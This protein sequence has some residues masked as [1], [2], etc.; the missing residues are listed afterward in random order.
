MSTLGWIAAYVAC[1]NIIGFILMGMDK[2]KAR[3]HAWRIAE[4][5]FFVVA[6]LGG[7]LGSILG[8]YTFRHKT[9]HWYFVVFMPIILLVQIGLTLYILMSPGINIQIQ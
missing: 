5:T 2:A 4:I 3:K 6:I 7:S 1:I 9:R 8:M